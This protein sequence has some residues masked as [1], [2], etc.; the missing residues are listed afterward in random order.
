MADIKTKSPV[1]KALKWALLLVL[2][3]AVVA[4]A[5]VLF[6]YPLS[7]PV[8]QE[9][10]AGLDYFSGCEIRAITGRYTREDGTLDTRGGGAGSWVLYENSAGEV[11]AVYLE[12][13]LVFPRYRIQANTDT[14]I[15]AGESSY[16][17][18]TPGFWSVQTVVVR[19]QKTMEITS[20]TFQQR[21]GQVAIS[22][23][24]YVLV[25]LG[26]EFRVADLVRWLRRKAE[27]MT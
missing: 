7:A 10:L 18:T 27:K 3:M 2:N 25:L 19:E 16:T 8:T 11:R 15:P 20:D 1:G 26:L 5:A 14:L 22:Y 4:A 6:F 9:G 21:R 13:D 12:W 24:L 23:G 17:F